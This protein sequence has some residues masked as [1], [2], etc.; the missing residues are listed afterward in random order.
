MEIEAIYILLMG[1]IY[2]MEAI[3]VNIIV[4][5]SMLTAIATEDYMDFLVITI[6]RII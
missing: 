3:L 6:N 2:G 1:I 5:V 4:Q